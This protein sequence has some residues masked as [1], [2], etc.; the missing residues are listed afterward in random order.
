VSCGAVNYFITVFNCVMVQYICAVQVDG[1]ATFRNSL[2][3]IVQYMI[4]FSSMY[5]YDIEF[6]ARNLKKFQ[7]QIVYC[8]SI[9]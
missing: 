7:A 4:V 2:I 3:A 8:D 6:T 5:D 9:T 1:S